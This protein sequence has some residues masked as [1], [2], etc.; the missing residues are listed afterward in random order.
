MKRKLNERLR[1]GK[2]IATEKNDKEQLERKAMSGR[3]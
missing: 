1:K 2:E 3:I